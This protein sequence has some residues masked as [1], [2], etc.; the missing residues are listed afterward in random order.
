MGYR[1]YDKAGV[2]VRWHF[3]HGLSYTEFAYSNLAVNGNTMSVTVRNTGKCAGAEVVQ[4]YMKAPQNGLHRP[5]RELKGFQKVFLQPGETQTVTFPL[6]DRSFAVWQDGWKIP[7]GAYTVCIGGLRGTIKKSGD[8]LPAPAWQKGS[9]YERCIGKPNQTDWEA[10]LGRTYTLP[11]LKKGSFTMDN[12]VMEMKDYSLIMKIMFKA[13]EATVAK[14]YGGK[15]D[16][17]NPNFRM[18]MACRSTDSQHD[19]FRRH[20]GRRAARYAGNG[21]RTLLPGNPENDQRLTNARGNTT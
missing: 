21:E 15:K 10:M 19:H 6:T 8:V 2:P 7:A 20:E 4:L 16:Y 14:G 18:Q 13:V 11:V 12:T 3:G 9:W 5:L 1:Y 17:D